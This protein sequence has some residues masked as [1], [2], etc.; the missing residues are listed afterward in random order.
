MQSWNILLMELF[1]M[2]QAGCMLQKHIYLPLNSTWM[3]TSERNW[4]HTKPAWNPLGVTENMLKPNFAT[5][6]EH[7]FDWVNWSDNQTRVFTARRVSDPGQGRT[8]DRKGV[9]RFT[10]HRS[11]ISFSWILCQGF[12]TKHGTAYWRLN[13]GGGGGWSAQ[14]TQPTI[15]LNM[16]NLRMHR[17]LPLYPHVLTKWCLIRPGMVLTFYWYLLWN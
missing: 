12:E 11:I 9:N 16:S 10:Q 6:P 2:L 4:K 1:P 13:W 5:T 14:G 7:N 3:T 8:G 15:H 17:A